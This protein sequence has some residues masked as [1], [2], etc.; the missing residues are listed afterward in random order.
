MLLNIVENSGGKHHPMRIL[1]NNY[2]IL[3]KNLSKK[4][5]GHLTSMEINNR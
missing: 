5:L 1:L 4:T 3:N 2:S